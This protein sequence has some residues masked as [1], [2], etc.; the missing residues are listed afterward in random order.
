MYDPSMLSLFSIDVLKNSFEKAFMFLFTAKSMA[1][2][3]DLMIFLKQKT[4]Q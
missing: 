1:K 3:N 2:R 4:D